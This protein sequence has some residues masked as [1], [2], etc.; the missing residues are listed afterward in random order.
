MTMENQDQEIIAMSHQIARMD[1]ELKQVH[2]QYKM[3]R[4]ISNQLQNERANLAQKLFAEHG[5]ILMA[6]GQVAVRRN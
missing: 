3:A 4:A 6:D 1:L 2:S 5:L